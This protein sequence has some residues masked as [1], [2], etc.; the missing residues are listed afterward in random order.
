MQILLKFMNLKR[1]TFLVGFLMCHC[2]LVWQYKVINFVE[3]PSYHHSSYGMYSLHTKV[4]HTSALS[5]RGHL[6]CM[7]NLPY[8]KKTACSDNFILFVYMV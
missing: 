7:T 5:L 8:N 3:D 2:I 4:L 6:L 1:V